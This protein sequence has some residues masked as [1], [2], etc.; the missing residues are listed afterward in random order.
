MKQWFRMAT[1][2]N[3]FVYLT[4]RYT[5][6]IVMHVCHVYQWVR[7]A[8]ESP[9]LLGKRST[10]TNV[11]QSGTSKFTGYV[12]VVYACSIIRTTKTNYP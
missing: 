3:Y 9:R 11:L 12:Q 5:L 7:G 10:G 8:V 1:D 2:Y 4:H 6:Y